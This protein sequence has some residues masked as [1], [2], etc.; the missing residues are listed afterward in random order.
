VLRLNDPDPVTAVRAFATDD[1]F[2]EA[3]AWQNP[4]VVRACL[5]VTRLRRKHELTIASYAQRYTVKN[6][7]I[8]FFGP[9]G[10]ARW[11]DCQ[12]PVRVRPAA[13]LITRSSVYFESW[14]IDALARALE[15]DPQLRPWLRPRLAAAYAVDDLLLLPPRGSPIR[16]DHGQCALLRRCDGTRTVR[17]LATEIGQAV[18]RVL[19]DLQRWCDIGVLRFGLT[20]PVEARPEVTLRRKLA[21]IGEPAVGQRALR[22][23]DRLESA[24]AG[25]AAAAGDPDMLLD[26]MATLAESFECIT[27]QAPTRRPGQLYAGRTLVYPDALRGVRVELGRPLLARLAP[28]LGLVLESARWLVAAIAER[29]RE[30]LGRLFECYRQPGTDE[31]P[32]PTLLASATPHLV[33]GRPYPGPVADAVAEFHQ[34]W[35]GILQIPDGARRHMVAADGIADR[36]RTEFPAAVPP[37]ETARYYSPDILI[38]ADGPAALDRGDFI[39]VLGELHLA[40][41][42]LE[43]RP[44]VEF[45]PSPASLMAAVESDL[46][47]R[48]IYYLPP[49]AW[50]RVSPRTYPSPLLSPHFTY[51]CLDDD[52]VATDGRLAVPARDLTVHRTGDH[53]MVRSA[54][55]GRELLLMEV[56]GEHLSHVVAD[57]FRL[58]PVR[59]HQ[60][61]VAIDTLV[62]QRESW[63]LPPDELSWAFLPSRG[64]RLRRGRDWWAAHSLPPRVFYRGPQDE[65]PRYVDIASASLVELLARTV[66]RADREPAERGISLTEALPDIDQTWLVDAHGARY[67]SELRCVVVDR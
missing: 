18:E 4:E 49:K 20:G 12:H 9:I 32:L 57:V 44:L 52:E 25:V 60:P 33:P 48:R 21:G 41:N 64:E 24:R 43:V 50:P 45:H 29:Y 11:T 7:T 35:L 8:G 46:G 23:L 42:T 66:R 37:W 36:V 63:H 39:G 2:R 5:D 19:I 59:T 55:T 53:L 6:D 54:R 15:T 27:G 10:W 34:R 26:R 61:R 30:L 22:C 13:E 56:L 31:V 40:R 28:P 3:M 47:D 16:L 58:T 17:Q 38:A 67:T 51:W 65:K 14:A 1:R 62:V